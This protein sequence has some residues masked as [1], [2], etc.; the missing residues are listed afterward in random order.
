MPKGFSQDGMVL[1]LKKSLYGL[2]QS[3]RN[4]YL[5]LK[6]KLEFVGFTQSESDACLFYTER[7]ICLIY[8]DDTLFYAQNMNDINSI[9]E[10]LKKTNLEL[11]VEDD[12]AGF[13]GVHIERKQNEG[14]I[15]LTQKGLIQ[16]I[17][18]A[19]DLGDRKPVSTPAAFGALGKDEDGEPAKGLYSYASVVGMLLYLS[20]HSRPDI[21]FAVTQC[22]RFTHN[23][24]RSHERALERIGL[25]LKGTA[26]MGLIL[27]P[28]ETLMLRIDCFVDADFA[29][30][31]GY[32]NRHDPVCVKS[33]TGYI[34]F[35]SGCP[36]HWISKLQTDIATSTMEAEYNALSMAMRDVLPLKDLVTEISKYLRLPNQDTTRIC[37]TIVH[38]DNA[39]CLKLATMEPGRMTPRSKHYG[40]KYHWFRSKLR[41]NQIEIYKVESENQRAD[42]LTKS[43]RGESFA[44]NRK[45]TCGW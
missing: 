15:E 11:E 12:V 38:E 35:I 2:K 31:W 45:L 40:V 5:H 44:F 37:R 26:D 28:Y 34:L 3:P 22:A 43:L 14:T 32:E 9:V 27:S 30:L 4:F 23:P 16:R 8:V 13:L 41:P 1:K 29:G 19:L 10:D 21:H 42:F 18:K 39:G 33:R 7:V 24:K 6:D 20:G 36:V 25:Y 17:I